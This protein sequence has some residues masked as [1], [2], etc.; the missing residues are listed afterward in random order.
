MKSDFDETKIFMKYLI[1]LIEECEN[2][3]KFFEMKGRAFTFKQ[4][5]Y[6]NSFEQLLILFLIVIVLINFLDILVEIDVYCCSAL[7]IHC[8]NS[9]STFLQL[10]SMAL[11]ISKNE[12]T[13]MGLD[14]FLRCM[15]FDMKI[16]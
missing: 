5:D 6:P 2:N 1:F 13:H 14:C 12:C 10:F 11:F 9:E 3:L 4:T 15:L 7:L 8:V 16:M